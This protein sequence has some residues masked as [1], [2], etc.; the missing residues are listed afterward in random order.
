[1]NKTI[2]IIPISYLSKI[3]ENLVSTQL[4]KVT[5]S[6]RDCGEV[7]HTWRMGRDTSGELL[8]QIQ[9]AI[10][11]QQGT[12]WQ[13]LERSRLLETHLDAPVLS[14][15]SSATRVGDAARRKQF[16]PD[17]DC[18]CS[19]RWTISRPNSNLD[20]LGRKPRLDTR[21]AIVWRLQWASI[22]DRSFLP[23]R[24]GEER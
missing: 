14:I 15:G 20:L 9:I 2:N 19:T 3:V 4:I 16:L 1:M 5:T 24:K 21:A 11:G 12:G 6:A 13:S 17:A 22:G 10:R 18:I 8:Q 23:S 7:I